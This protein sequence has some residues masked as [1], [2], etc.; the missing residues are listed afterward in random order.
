MGA[1]HSGEGLPPPG[2]FLPEQG[3]GRR[4]GA[5]GAAWQSPF[6]CD[7]AA[8]AC[9]EKKSVAGGDIRIAHNRP[10]LSKV[11]PARGGWVGRPGVCAP[12][13]RVL[14]SMS[15]TCCAAQHGPGGLGAAP[16]GRA[17]ERARVSRTSGSWTVAASSRRRRPTGS[18]D[19]PSGYLLSRRARLARPAVRAG[20]CVCS[21]PAN[22][23]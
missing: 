20:A 5:A 9:C 22:L 16:P 4:D 10:V 2:V 14:P 23:L 6:G 8:R 21:R 19:P 12:P 3:T 15:C 1:A 11:G 17:A 13:A 7:S 18:C